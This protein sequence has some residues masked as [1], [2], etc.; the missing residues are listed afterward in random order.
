MIGSRIESINILSGTAGSSAG[1]FRWR[2]SDTDL[3]ITKLFGLGDVG[4]PQPL[5]DSDVSWNVLLGGAIARYAGTNRFTDTV[6]EGNESRTSGLVMSLEGGVR[7]SFPS[8]FSSR[9]TLG[10]IYGRTK[11]EFDANT[12]AG[13][14]AEQAF[15]GGFVNWLVDTLTIAPSLDLAWRPRFGDFTLMPSSRIIYFRTEQLHSTSDELDVAGDSIS[16]INRLDGD[17]KTPWDI[18]GYPLHFGGHFSRVD[19]G[20]NLRDG[21]QSNYFYE[22]GPRLVADVW[23]DLWIIQFLGLSATYFWSNTLS[24]W[25]W[26]IEMNLKF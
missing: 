20:G 16:W 18:G 17:Y 14:Q 7:F 8:D 3:Q 1:L 10:L 4:E 15:G 5:G 13:L 2:G 12:P 26:A 11:S 24:G 22:I 9:A 21:L 6:L 25:T 19:L 23:E